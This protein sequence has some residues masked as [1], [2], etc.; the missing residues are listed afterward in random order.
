VASTLLAWSPLR[1]IHAAWS[2][3][4]SPC[5]LSAY[6]AS[7]EPTSCRRSLPLCR[8]VARFQSP[9][10]EIGLGIGNKWGIDTR[11]EGPNVVIMRIA[12]E[13]SGKLANHACAI[14]QRVMPYVNLS[15]FGCQFNPQD[16]N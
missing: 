6:A 9:R 16:K 8:A 5:R 13:F 2:A 4:T 7:A 3:S 11:V 1:R 14:I 15:R 12:R 10:D